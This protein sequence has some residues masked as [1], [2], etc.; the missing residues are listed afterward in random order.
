MFAFLTALNETTNYDEMSQMIGELSMMSDI[1]SL[2]SNMIQIAVS[3]FMC[4]VMWKIF[5]KAG[6]EG[7]KYLIPFYG[8][9]TECK[10]IGKKWIFIAELLM[11]PVIMISLIMSIVGFAM[12]LVAAFESGNSESSFMIALIGLIVFGITC[13]VSFVINIIYSHNLSKAFGKG[14]GFTIGLIFL[15]TIFKAII[16]FSP[17]IQYIYGAP[18]NAYQYDYNYNDPNIGTGTLDGISTDSRLNQDSGN[19]DESSFN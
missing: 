3:V 1:M 16:A 9:Y 10:I 8:R 18:V 2:L 13:I 7:W 14:T 19:Y 5:V 17:N 15:P 11:V 4:V 12:G 6:E